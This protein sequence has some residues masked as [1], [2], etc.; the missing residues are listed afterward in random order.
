MRREM[1]ITAHAS[2]T[3]RPCDLTFRNEMKKRQMTPLFK[4]YVSASL[5][6]RFSLY[7]DFSDSPYTLVLNLGEYYWTGLKR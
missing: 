4:C 7:S 6:R 3:L 2:L 5:R 1:A